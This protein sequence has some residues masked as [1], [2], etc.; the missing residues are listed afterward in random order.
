MRYGTLAKI[1]VTEKKI[2]I[3][4]GREIIKQ[5]NVLEVS[6]FC[7][8]GKM[9][10]SFRCEIGRMFVVARKKCELWTTS[11]GGFRFVHKDAKGRIRI[12]KAVL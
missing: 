5:K 4:S 12:A 11:S 6:D 7:P 2:S 10:V 3:L 8:V 1:P 9:P